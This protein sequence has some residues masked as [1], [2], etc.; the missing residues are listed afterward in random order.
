MLSQI[1]FAVTALLISPPASENGVS[2][3][4]DQEL[5][6]SAR[7]IETEDMVSFEITGPN[8]VAPTIYVDFN[9]NGA[10]DR[11]QDFAAGI[12][13]G[14]SACL[15]YLITETSSTTCQPQGQKVRIEQSLLGPSAVTTFHFPKREI[16]RASCR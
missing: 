8:T 5:Q 4:K 2:L 3:G 6:T 15:S 9:R 12:E 13:P 16:G 11:N 10:V 14:G 1:A 7:L